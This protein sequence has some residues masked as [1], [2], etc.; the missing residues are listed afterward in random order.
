M[1]LPSFFRNCRKALLTATVA[2]AGL[3]AASPSADA[4][5]VT[6]L[7]AFGP[8]GGSLLWVGSN[9]NV[10][11]GVNLT[12]PP[13]IQ[14]AGR[15]DFGV[16]TMLTEAVPGA[17]HSPRGIDSFGNIYGSVTG[18]TSQP[19]KWLSGGS[20]IYL[21]LLAGGTFGYVNGVSPNGTAIGTSDSG[22]TQ[23][24]A[25]WI[26][27]QPTA[28]ALPA[29]ATS[30]DGASVADNSFGAG[31][32]SFGSVQRAVQ[33][34]TAGV[35]TVLPFLTGGSRSAAKAVNAAGQVAGQGDTQGDPTKTV[36]IVWS[37]GVSKK[38]PKLNAKTNIWEARWINAAGD[39]VG[40]ANGG[41]KNGGTVHAVLWPTPYTTAVELPTPGTL[42]NCYAY[43]INDAGV[44]VG[45][46]G[47]PT[48]WQVPVRWDP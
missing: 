4:Y 22:G 2:L 8:L 32:C 26:N 24:A 35:P 28:L 23:L 20:P 16:L 19:L 41:T 18:T 5:T 7:P 43:G 46:C 25:L 31:T 44:I 45:N 34:S 6:V 37:L 11:L 36:G 42:Y 12:S 39:A 14:R 48:G 15:W 38:L 21:P 40:N 13:L 9:P 17:N 33:W 10:V 3:C 27:N 1:R 29:G 30:C 47:N